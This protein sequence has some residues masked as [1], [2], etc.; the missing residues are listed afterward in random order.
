MFYLYLTIEI[1]PEAVADPVLPDGGGVGQ[2]QPATGVW[3]THRVSVFR[4]TQKSSRPAKTARVW[5]LG[6]TLNRSASPGPSGRRPHGARDEAG[7]ELVAEGP[8][9]RVRGQGLLRRALTFPRLTGAA[10]GRSLPLGV[11]HLN[12]QP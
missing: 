4:L 3:Y 10:L 11:R 2:A 9:D 6:R 12:F 7:T 8:G 1:A 5:I